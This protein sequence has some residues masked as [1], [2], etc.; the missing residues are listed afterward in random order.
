MWS[1]S[2]LSEQVV[3]VRTPHAQ[4]PVPSCIPSGACL[5]FCVVEADKGA[6]VLVINRFLWALNLNV[7]AA[8]VI[9]WIPYFIQGCKMKFSAGVSSLAFNSLH[10]S[11]KTSPSS[12]IWFLWDTVCT[13]K[14]AA[15]VKSDTVCLSTSVCVLFLTPASHLGKIK[16]HSHPF[17]AWSTEAG[18][19]ARAYRVPSSHPPTN[20]LV[21]VLC[22]SPTRMPS[23]PPLISSAGCSS[24]CISF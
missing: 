18:D 23:V 12:I 8:I 10:S 5:T 9:A 17:Y 16:V 24:L 21:T 11:M 13:R 6:L 22:A 2:L 4:C 14:S 1:R 20:S 3:Q 7:L 19:R 15:H